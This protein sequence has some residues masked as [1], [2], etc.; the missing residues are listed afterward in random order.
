MPHSSNVSTISYFVI[1]NSYNLCPEV[2]YLFLSY[3]ARLSTHAKLT[4]LF[5]ALHFIIYWLALD[6]DLHIVI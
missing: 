1:S 5:L 3:L 4:V 6:L 2:I